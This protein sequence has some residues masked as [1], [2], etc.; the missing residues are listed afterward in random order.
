MPELE[1]DGHGGASLDEH[2]TWSAESEF[3][4]VGKMGLGREGVRARNYATVSCT[5][6]PCMAGMAGQCT[7][8]L[9]EAYP[10]NHTIS[11]FLRE[12]QMGSWGSIVVKSSHQVMCSILEQQNV[13]FDF[14]QKKKKPA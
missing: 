1:P 2:H 4:P 12:A 10:N 5:F 3:R 6:G 9:L 13:A 11:C 8:T 14:F 7:S